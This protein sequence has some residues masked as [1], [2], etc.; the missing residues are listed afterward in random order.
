[1]LCAV[2]CLAAVPVGLCGA[3]AFNPDIGALY[4]SET[5]WRIFGLY[6]Y[7]GIFGGLLLGPILLVVGVRRHR[8]QRPAVSHER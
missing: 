5:L 8:S 6:A 1:M 2:F 4:R 3:A 7:F